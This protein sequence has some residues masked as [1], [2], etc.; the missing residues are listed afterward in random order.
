MAGRDDDA[1][2]VKDGVPIKF[3]FHRSVTQGRGRIMRDVERHGGQ[4]VLH[5]RDANVLLVD[6]QEDLSFLRRRYYSSTERYRLSLYLEPRGFVQSCIRR[7]DY[8]H[9]GPIKQGMPGMAPRAARGPRMPFTEEDREHLA[10]YLSTRCPTRDGRMGNSAYKDLERLGQTNDPS[11]AWASRHTFHSWR[12]HYKRYS[13]IMDGRIEYYMGRLKNVGHHFGHDPRRHNHR[14]LRQEEE[15]DD[16]EEEEED[17][18]ERQ[19]LERQGRER[20]EQVLPGAAAERRARDYLARHEQDLET[21]DEEGGGDVEQEEFAIQEAQRVR[22]HGQHPRDVQQTQA[23]RARVS[24]RSSNGG[25]ASGVEASR[26]ESRRVRESDGGTEESQEIEGSDLFG[27]RE[28]DDSQDVNFPMPIS[29]RASP[30]PEHD[31][32]PFSTQATL[33]ASPFAAEKQ[34]IPVPDPTPPKVVESQPSTVKPTAP[35]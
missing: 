24:E 28:F 30:F 22:R 32:A 13:E 23:K 14:E 34:P 20:R 12:E 3:C 25:R 33:V 11:W 2:F 7:G 4:I 5:E 26:G 19:G 27:D 15:E 29:P 6:E 21:F 9:V 16:E 31:G 10:Y 8:R 35:T 1:L 18:E 17:D